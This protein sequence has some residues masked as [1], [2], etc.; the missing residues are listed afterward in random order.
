MSNHRESRSGS[1]SESAG[2]LRH[3]D[4]PEEL[5][6]GYESDQSLW[7]RERL[8]SGT[9]IN[10]AAVAWKR[11]KLPPPTLIPQVTLCGQ[12]I[13][14]GTWWGEGG[15]ETS[16]ER[17]QICTFLLL[18]LFFL[19]DGLLRFRQACLMLKLMW[20]PKGWWG[21]ESTSPLTITFFEE[22]KLEAFPVFP[23]S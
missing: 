6:S 13:Y 1:F 19:V 22:G 2:M 21:G 7:S 20:I 10:C 23:I 8:K 14:E 17:L 5:L 3:E 15:V 9:I 11:K 12:W 4:V 18:S 16:T